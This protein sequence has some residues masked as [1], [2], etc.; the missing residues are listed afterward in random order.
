[1]NEGTLVKQLNGIDSK[2]E[3]DL[4]NGE[5][6][7]HQDKMDLTNSL[8][9][10]LNDKGRSEDDLDELSTSDSR[11]AD[12]RS[13]NELINKSLEDKPP[14][15]NRSEEKSDDDKLDK[16]EDDKQQ[17]KED[18]KQQDREDDESSNYVSLNDSITNHEYMTAD[19]QSIDQSSNAS[20]SPKEPKLEEAN[21]EFVQLFDNPDLLKR[22]IRAGDQ[23]ASKPE[24]TCEVLVNLEV[25][26]NDTNE[27][28]ESE[29][30]QN[31]TVLIGDYDLVHGVDLALLTM[32]KGEIAEILVRPQLAYGPAGKQPDIKSN[33]VLLCKVELLKVTW[34]NEMVC[35]SYETMRHYFNLTKRK[36]ERGNFFFKRQE[37]TTAAHCYTRAGEILDFL[38]QDMVNRH[39]M[40]TDCESKTTDELRTKEIAGELSSIN[41]LSV[42]YMKVKLDVFN[43]LSAVHIKLKSY[44]QALDA[45]DN[46]LR[47]NPND[48]KALYRKSTILS[49]KGCLEE[50]I[51]CLKYAL[52]LDP[53]NRT[54][55]SELNKLKIKLKK[56][57]KEEKAL[58]AKMLQPKKKIKLNAKNGSGRHLNYLATGLVISGVVLG[59][60]ILYRK[61]VKS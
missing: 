47:I 37:F 44:N 9:S 14:G 31:L 42:E 50:A 12:G 6:R 35:E 7:A 30:E 51:A 52:K 5:L 46:A 48:L 17:N 22:I 36:K 61:F 23:T 59:S 20:S 21:N 56:E 43:N 38:G 40:L 27:R 49:H 15:S 45:V 24:P 11:S 58:Y 26:D 57:I 53:K 4:I 2:T 39:H 18:D 25:M 16:E 55:A 33:C 3:T 8:K 29:C 10:D 19:Q 54:F 28:I 32:H 34:P 41:E 60:F 13:I 1:M